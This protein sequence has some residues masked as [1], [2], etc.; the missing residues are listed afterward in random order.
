MIDI[1][2]VEEL[3]GARYSKFEIEYGKSKKYEWGVVSE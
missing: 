3:E 1:D 2:F